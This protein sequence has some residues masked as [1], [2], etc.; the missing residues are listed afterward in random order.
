MSSIIAL[1]EKHGKLEC[2]TPK[3][4]KEKAPPFLCNKFQ[5]AR[6]RLFTRPKPL[7]L[8]VP[9]EYNNKQSFMPEAIAVK[10]KANI[11]S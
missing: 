9:K 4:A 5:S 10:P 1:E 2:I 6:H 8:S 11:K 3:E 7:D